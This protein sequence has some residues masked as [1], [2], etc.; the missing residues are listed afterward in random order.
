MCTDE[1][2]EYFM[3]LQRK[4]AVI[5]GVE[6]HVCVQQ[7]ALDLLSRGI[8]VHI[9]ADGVSSQRPLD[10]EMALG[11]LQQVLRGSEEV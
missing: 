8:Q 9:L 3:G 1:F 5:F 4:D 6:T 11:R 7:T 2:L 10:R